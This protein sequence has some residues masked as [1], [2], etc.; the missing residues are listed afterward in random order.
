MYYQIEGTNVR[1]AGSMHFVPEGAT[2]PQWV[3]DAYR[4]SEEVYFESNKDDLP[5]HTLLPCGRSSEANVPADLWANMKAHW[6]AHMPV[7]GPQKLWTIA[8]VLGT[9]GLRLTYGVEHEVTE[10]TKTDS[11]EIKYLETVDEFVQLQDAVPDSDYVSAFPIILNTPA[12]VRARNIT[13]LYTAWMSGQAE[14]VSAVINTTPLAQF[15]RV[16]TAMFDAR[17]ALWLPRIIDIIRSGKRTVIYV[18]AGHVGGPNGLLS[19]L[20]RSRHDVITLLLTS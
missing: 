9:T 17:N 7:L 8:I 14:A 10:L 6:P 20:A 2:V 5:R 19:L 1:L 3:F 11:R 12:D 4:W 18:G 15:P 13:A 16:K